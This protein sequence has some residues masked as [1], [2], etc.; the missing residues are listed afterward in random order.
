MKA[1]HH[2]VSVTV[3]MFLLGIAVVILAQNQ[4]AGSNPGPATQGVGLIRNDPGAYG[5]YTL[6]S[7][8]QSTSTFLIDMEGRVVKTWDTDSTP[9][10]LAYLL[11]SG[12]LL[13][14]GLAPNPPFGRTAGGGGKMQEFS[15]NGELVWDFAYGTATATQ[16][17]DFW[18]M[19]N[20]NVLMLVKEKKSAAEA[21][22]AGRIPSSV[23]GCGPT[24]LR[25]AQ[26]SLDSQRSCGRGSR[27]GLQQRRYAARQ[28]VFEH[29]RNCFAG[30]FEW[31]LSTGRGQ[32]V[33]SGAGHLELLGTES[34]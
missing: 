31:A 10:S 21:I 22:A 30:G 33:R 24:A 2:R 13:R 9:S 32:E 6:I 1:I 5:G 20:G 4:P 25:P 23:Q 27:S 3:L 34:H 17:H 28:H 18:R 26:C 11:E 12:N 8:L 14:A 7:P 16:H 19:P 29:R 15:W